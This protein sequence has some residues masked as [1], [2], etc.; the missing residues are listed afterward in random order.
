M[1]RILLYQNINYMYTD[2]NKVCDKLA[3]YVMHSKN[4]EIWIFQ[5]K[6]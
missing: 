5:V 6:R 4:K 3:H 1:Q 2:L